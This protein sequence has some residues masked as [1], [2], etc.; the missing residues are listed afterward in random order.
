MEVSSEQLLS[1]YEKVNQIA[2]GPLHTLVKSDKNRLFS[3][4]YGETY[5]LG[6]GNSSSLNQF[7]EISNLGRVLINLGPRN[8]GLRSDEVEKIATGI[9]HS[10]AVIGGKAYLW[11]VCGSSKTL[12][13][14]SPQFFEVRGTTDNNQVFSQFNL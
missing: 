14:R 8:S 9:T 3:T 13:L 6:H 4:G 5:A 2:C 10:G 11:G 7:K 12:I 1:A